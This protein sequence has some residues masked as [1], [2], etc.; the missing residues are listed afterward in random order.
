MTIRN[1]FE[2][3]DKGFKKIDSQIGLWVWVK[4]TPHRQYHSRCCSFQAQR[5]SSPHWRLSSILKEMLTYWCNDAI[6]ELFWINSPSVG[7][8]EH[9]T[10]RSWLNASTKTMATCSLFRSRSYWFWNECAR[11][12]QTRTFAHIQ[13]DMCGRFGVSHVEI[14]HSFGTHLGVFQYNRKLSVVVLLTLAYN[15]KVLQMVYSTPFLSMSK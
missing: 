15:G 9:Q 7:Q 11:V 2:L 14:K 3:V 8:V 1:E 6:Q 10:M 12:R 5:W 4:S 13:Q